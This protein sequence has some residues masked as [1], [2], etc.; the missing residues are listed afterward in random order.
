MI[1]KYPET[2]TLLTT[3]VLHITMNPNMLII[4]RYVLGFTSYK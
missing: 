3:A 1:P 4:N 2:G